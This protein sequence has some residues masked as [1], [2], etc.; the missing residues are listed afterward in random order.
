MIAT[1][2]IEWVW[3]QATGSCSHV[4]IGPHLLCYV[5]RCV[6]CVDQKLYSDGCRGLVG[7]GAGDKLNHSCALG[8]V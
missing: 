4:Y 6:P 8:G 7:S 3:I 5:L 1:H 2:Y